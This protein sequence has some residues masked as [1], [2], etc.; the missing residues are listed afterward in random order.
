LG[1]PWIRELLASWRAQGKR[2]EIMQ[3]FFGKPRKGRRHLA[4]IMEHEE[5]DQKIHAEV[6]RL[7]QEGHGYNETLHLVAGNLGK[8]GIMQILSD[9]AIRSIYEKRQAGYTALRARLA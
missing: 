7:L 3:L 1:E 9:R 5:R 2:E 4:T 8:L 6:A